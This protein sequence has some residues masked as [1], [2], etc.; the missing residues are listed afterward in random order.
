VKQFTHGNIFSG[1]F[2]LIIIIGL[3]AYFGSDLIDVR[4]RK[5]L[6]LDVDVTTI[7][8]KELAKKK[9]KFGDYLNGMNLFLK[10]A[11]D[12]NVD[13][14]LTDNKFFEVRAYVVGD[15]GNDAEREPTK[16][17]VKLA[18]CKDD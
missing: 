13:F 7:S 2:S 14:N 17:E 5:G 6:Q 4:E 11:D 8:N 10:V 3:G 1:C 18:K 15:S 9:I 12:A 16:N